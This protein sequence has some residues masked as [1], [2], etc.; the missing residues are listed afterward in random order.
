MQTFRNTISHTLK[1]MINC[2]CTI[3]IFDIAY[4]RA[5]PEPFFTLSKEL[6]PGSKY[7]PTKSHKFIKHLQN[8]GRLQRNFTQNI[9]GLERLAGIDPKFIVESH[10]TYHTARCVG[11]KI[12]H[13]D[14]E[15][16]EHK[17][18]LMKAIRTP[19][20]GK[21]YSLEFIKEH[22][23]KDSIPIC[24]S[25]GGIVKPDI[26]FFYE[27]LPSR[28]YNCLSDFETCDALII[29]G[30]SLAVQPFADLINHVKT[31]VPR[32]LINMETLDH[33]FDFENKRDAFFKG[34]CDEGVLAFM[35]EM[36]WKFDDDVS[37]ELIEPAEHR[38]FDKLQTKSTCNVNQ[39]SFTYYY[40][41]QPKDARFVLGG[42]RIDIIISTKADT[43]HPN[44]IVKNLSTE[45]NKLNLN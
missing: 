13:E 10:G 42:T 43:G 28:F 24:E 25:C 41:S 6:I 7:Q 3:A 2:L 30:T 9:D 11:P 44:N 37:D 32:L 39:K 38:N 36:E 15:D 17:I 16:S 23:S 21:P 27:S 33:L 40:N 26:T 5:N 8:V 29:M 31:D 22:V 19:G 45:V 12:E 4:F 20:C 14:F 1:V 35:N 18:A 34:S